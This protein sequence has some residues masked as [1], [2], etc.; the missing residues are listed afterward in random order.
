MES[1]YSTPIKFVSLSVQIV[2]G[3]LLLA[4]SLIKVRRK[5]SVLKSP[6]KSKCKARVVKQTKTAP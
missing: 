2:F 3:F 6:T 1:S 5:L 4:M